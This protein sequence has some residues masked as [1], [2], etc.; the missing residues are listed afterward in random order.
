MAPRGRCTFECSG[1]FVPVQASLAE[2]A[3]TRVVLPFLAAAH[4]MSMLLDGSDDAPE[5]V[6]G[7]P[8]Q[9]TG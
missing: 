6:S 7:V 8:M 5:T 3:T 9:P 1:P 4:A 2:D